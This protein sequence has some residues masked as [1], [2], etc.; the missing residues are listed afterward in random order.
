MVRF[1]IYGTGFNSNELCFNM[2][3]QSKMLIVHACHKHTVQ[4]SPE[5]SV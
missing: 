3:I 1:Y 5:L 4:L 2:L